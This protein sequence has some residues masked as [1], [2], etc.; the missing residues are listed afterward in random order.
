MYSHILSYLLDCENSTRGLYSGGLISDRNEDKS[1]SDRWLPRKISWRMVV[2]PALIGCLPAGMH[3]ASFV[4]VAAATPQSP[5]ATVSVT[6]PSS[7][8]AGD[9]NIVVVGWNDTTASVQSVTDSAGNSYKVAVGPT[10]G[11]ALEQ[12]IYYAASILGGSNTVTVTFNQAATY[13]DVRILE[14]SGVS[15]LDATAG[16][17]GNSSSASS[18]SA[19]T[20]NANELI[21]GA[22]MVATQTSGVGSGFTKRVITSPDSD[23]A[24]DKTTNSAGANSATASLTSS[25]PWVMQMAT[26]VPAVPTVTSVSANN[27]STAGGTAV[28][29][30]GTN[31]VSGATVKFGSAAATNVTVASSTTIKATTPAGTAG[32]ATVTVT[33]PNGLSGSLANGF[34]YVSGSAISFVQVAAATPQ[35]PT[36]TVSVSYSSSEKAGDMNV[37]VVGWNDTTASVQSVKDSV[38]N[39]Y[40][41]AVGPTKG[42][43]LEQ[44]I[45][46]AASILGG[47][48]T[49]TVTFNQAATYPDV[50][51]L[52]YSGVASLDV[53][54][55]ASGN[56]SSASSGSA[57]T[58]NANELIFGAN[59]VA[60]QTSG[61]GSGFTK[62]VITSPDSDL[63]ED[64]T[65]TSTGANSATATLTS[66]GPWVMQM[67]TFSTAAPTLTVNASLGGMS[68]SSSSETGAAQDAC[69]VALTG[70]APSGGVVIA[71][72]SNNSAV[73]VPAS[74]TVASGA[75]SAGFT[76][77]V[78]A[79][80]STQTATLTASGAGATSSFP[81]QLNAAAA[82]LSLSSKSVAF[83]NVMENTPS[84]QSVVLTSSG[85]AALTIS[86][87]SIA[88]TGFSMSGVTAPITLNPGQTATLNIQFDPTSTGSMSGAVTLTSNASSTPTATVTLSGTGQ[89]TSYQVDL[90]WGAPSSSTDAVAGYD[91][92]R[93]VSGGSSYQLLNSSA[94]GSTT[95]TDTTVQTNTTYNYYIVSVDAQG[96][97]SSPSNTFTVTIP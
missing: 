11:T 32:G 67:A 86:G 90:T 69:T 63:A 52:E 53:T 62:R 13:P 72:A 95:Y 27:G 50:R 31:F 25:G 80:S 48:N 70:A 30:T 58:K 28:T 39:T 3:A 57:T 37:V 7:E 54:A 42:T 64:R 1:Q 65:V 73:S 84:T 41:L 94:D 92:Y 68:C 34:T 21:F 22:N 97:Q 59:M 74:V 71:L 46:Y 66:S 47:S 55:G 29:I 93:E 14:Y 91:I 18:G 61:A 56:S 36:A 96:N 43:A 24:E 9:M 87:A 20:K 60:T 12:S 33:D 89:A 82:A 79:V 16:A 17:S 81:L 75:S 10:K 88:G 26:F 38:G 19:T 45:Y 85:T 35:S 15:G 77:T 23:L 6:Y 49:V 83:G 40:K 51:V 44:S 76:A 5:T 8:K 78:S 4:Q 2:I